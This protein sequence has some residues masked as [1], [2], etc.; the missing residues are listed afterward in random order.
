MS[1]TGVSLVLIGRSGLWS[2][3]ADNIH[4]AALYIK[5]Q[6]SRYQTSNLTRAFAKYSSYSCDPWRP[7]ADLVFKINHDVLSTSFRQLPSVVL[8]IYGH[9]V[10]TRI[11]SKL[12]AISSACMLTSIFAALN[13][14]VESSVPVPMSRR[15]WYIGFCDNQNG[16][17]Q[18]HSG[19]TSSVVN[20]S[21]ATGPECNRQTHHWHRNT[22]AHH[23][24][25]SESALAPSYVFAKRSNCTYY[26]CIWCIPAVL[27]PTCL[28][29]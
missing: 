8:I 13:P 22:R 2:D 23:S 12:S 25:A 17:L 10:E 26:L 1:V 28:P 7:L 18:L 21:T 11:W 3:S 27:L 9:Q 16:L 5:H 6:A 4:I 24:C 20:R 29:W 14:S 15:V 19:S